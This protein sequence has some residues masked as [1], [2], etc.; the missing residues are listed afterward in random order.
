MSVADNAVTGTSKW[1]ADGDIADY[2]GPG[3]FIAVK[4]E[5]ID[6]RATSV[7]VGLQPSQG[8]GLVEIIDDPDKNGVFKIT[9]KDEQKFVVIISDGTQTTT[10]EFDLSGLALEADPWEGYTK[11][12]LANFNCEIGGN[13]YTKGV[14]LS[15]IIDGNDYPAYF[16]YD[17]ESAFD[18]L[19]IGDYYNSEVLQRHTGPEPSSDPSDTMSGDQYNYEKVGDNLVKF[20]IDGAA[21]SGYEGYGF[22]GLD[23]ARSQD[24]TN[25]FSDLSKVTFYYK[26]N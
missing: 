24:P 9:D 12:N 7:R 25:I 6:E 5:D 20:S 4:F 22:Y 1:L 19:S 8:S 3:N 26:N 11:V 10:Q 14:D 17:C 16:E 21:M 23:D 2:W 13:L 18:N 15:N